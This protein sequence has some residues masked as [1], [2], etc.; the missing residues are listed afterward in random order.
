[1]F[2]D[3]ASEVVDHKG[4]ESP[5]PMKPRS[6]QPPHTGGRTRNSP[7]KPLHPDE[8]ENMNPDEVSWVLTHPDESENMNPD[9]V[10]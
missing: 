7:S 8:S 1:M 3:S 2:Q 6:L 10:S 5:S 9:E 4:A